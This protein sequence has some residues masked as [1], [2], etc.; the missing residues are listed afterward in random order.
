LSIY[1][2]IEE[3]FLNLKKEAK[4]IDTIHAG[5]WPILLRSM[6]LPTCD[7]VF[8][9][10]TRDLSLLATSVISLKLIERLNFLESAIGRQ[11]LEC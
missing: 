3:L 10:R 9:M 5:N 1:G 6:M 7:K 4:L 2:Q 11:L 8:T